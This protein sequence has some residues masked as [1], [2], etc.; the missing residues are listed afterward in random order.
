M[1]FLPA[2]RPPA[3]IEARA[4]ASN[5]TEALDILL[6]TRQEYAR[7]R[8]EKRTNPEVSDMRMKLA[9]QLY[10][11][12]LRGTRV[13]KRVLDEQ[14]RALTRAFQGQGG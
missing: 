6:E 14:W 12:A 5:L 7:A 2:E 3:L 8:R 1:S 13:N 4:A 10:E 9:L 11:T